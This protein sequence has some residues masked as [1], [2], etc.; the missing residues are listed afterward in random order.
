MQA[1]TGSRAAWS[2][3]RFTQEHSIF[4]RAPQRQQRKMVYGLIQNIQ[5]WPEKQDSQE[6]GGQMLGPPHHKAPCSSTPGQKDVLDGADLKEKQKLHYS[7]NQE[8]SKS[9]AHAG[10][11]Q[12]SENEALPRQT[13][14][15]SSPNSQQPMEGGMAGAWSSRASLALSLR[16]SKTS[17]VFFVLK[18]STFWKRKCTASRQLH[19][20]QRCSGTGLKSIF[21]LSVPYLSA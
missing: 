2:H 3:E 18:S 8:A 6:R 11:I 13:R 17:A 12:R 21:V 16:F 10:G 20:A 5:E 14:R 1:G 9:T 7:K 4:I 19:P 15:A